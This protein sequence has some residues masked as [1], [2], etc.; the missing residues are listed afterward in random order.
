MAKRVHKRWKK[1]VRA[2]S[3]AVVA[4]LATAAAL[5]VA[6]ADDHELQFKQRVYVGAGVGVTELNPETNSAAL[7]VS[8]STDTGFHVTVGYDFTSRLSAEVYYADLGQADISFLGANVG[9]VDYQVFGLSGIAYLFNSRSGFSAR[10]PSNGIAARQG[11]SLYGRVGLGGVSADSELDYTVNHRT[12]L[13]LGLGA[14]Y[15]F[16]NGFAVRGELMALD[17]DQ[18][19]A[20]ISLIKRFGQP[21]RQS[22]VPATNT[23]ST[24]TNVETEK[25]DTDVNRA[26]NPPALPFP[27][28]N[29]AFDK[30]DINPEAARKLDELVAVLSTSNDR[31]V[32]EGHTDWIAS[33]SYNYNLSLRRAEN[34]K[35]Y[36]E[37]KG[38]AAGRI[39][40]QAYGETR[41]VASNETVGGRAANRRVDI[42]LDQ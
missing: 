17:T 29:F 1:S 15:G 34:V 7:D 27:T 4:M 39:S 18:Q 3:V 9:S 12:H 13:A 40:M 16:D 26:A 23:P 35:R 8:E 2:L 38:I 11:L 30:S 10:S 19:Y 31:L 33:E 25:P 42:R 14:E 6:R 32:L 22:S 37:Q 36:L 41:P 21:G 20:T 24:T 5:M 28:V